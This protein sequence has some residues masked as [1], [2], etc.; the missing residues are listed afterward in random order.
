MFGLHRAKSLAVLTVSKANW[1]LGPGRRLRKVW[2]RIDQNGLQETPEFGQFELHNCSTHEA[3]QFFRDKWPSLVK[4]TSCSGR[5]I[6]RGQNPSWIQQNRHLGRPR[7]RRIAAKYPTCCTC[8]RALGLGE[9]PCGWSGLSIIW[10]SV[11][12]T[13]LLRLMAICRLQRT[14]R[15]A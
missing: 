8:F 10:A 15:T 11:R 7:S 6:Q 5:L 1:R 13:R 2:T 4:R 3:A 9:S 14:S 12:G